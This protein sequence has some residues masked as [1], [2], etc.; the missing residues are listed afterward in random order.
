MHYD[1]IMLDL[2]VIAWVISRAIAPEY[3]CEFAG[4]CVSDFA[5][6]ALWWYNVRYDVWFYNYENLCFEIK[7]DEKYL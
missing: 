2:P 1:G 4:E 6:Y 3:K 5:V 7:W